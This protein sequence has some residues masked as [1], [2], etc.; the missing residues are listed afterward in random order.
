MSGYIFVV[1]DDN[2]IRSAIENGLDLLGYRVVSAANGQEALDKLTHLDKPCMIFLDLMMPVMSGSQ[3]RQHQVSNPKLAAVPV[4]VISADGDAR[5]KSADMKV[6]E[7]LRKPFDFNSL[8]KVAA[9]YCG[10]PPE[11][12]LPN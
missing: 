5:Q 9:R 12:L 2:D 10:P 4:I 8:A 6:T 3:F 7:V 1:D 11:N